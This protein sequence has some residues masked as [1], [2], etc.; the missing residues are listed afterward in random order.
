MTGVGLEPT[1]PKWLAPKDSSLFHSTILT[2]FFVVNSINNGK[3]YHMQIFKIKETILCIG[4]HQNDENGSQTHEPKWLMPLTSASYH[5]AILP[6]CV[7]VNSMDNGKRYHLQV[8]NIKDTILCI[9]MRQNVRNGAQ[10]HGTELTG[11]FNQHLR[12]NG[13]LGYMFWG[14]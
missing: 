11:A 3:R 1:P 9:A 4:R 12:L 5:S 10:T 7:V 6:V 13:H 14:Q 8:F 2:V